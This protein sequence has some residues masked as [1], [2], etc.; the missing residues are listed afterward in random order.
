MSK[1]EIIKQQMA[2]L[3]WFRHECYT[4]YEN[5]EECIRLADVWI[6][7]CEEREE[8]ELAQALLNEK[9]RIISGESI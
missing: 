1:E 3:A 9:N 6:K 8:Y 2:L 4:R 7:I 5:D